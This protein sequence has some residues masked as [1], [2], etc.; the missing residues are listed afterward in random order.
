MTLVRQENAMG[1]VLKI[2]KSLSIH[3]VTALREELLST[4]EKHEQ[5]VLA[6]DEVET[7]D[8]AGIQLLC[9]ARKTADA[10]GKIVMI[11]SP[12]SAVL[13]VLREI[14]NNAQDFLDNEDFGN[15]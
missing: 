4:L 15:I 12:S 10:A 11:C 6:L 5:L 3:Q 14:G 13:D 8:A 2:G 9:S 1:A 7:C